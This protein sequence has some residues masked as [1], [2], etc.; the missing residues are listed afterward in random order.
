MHSSL[1]GKAAEIRALLLNLIDTL[2]EGAALPP[3]R[4]A[5]GGVRRRAW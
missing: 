1:P 5:V 4:E 3:E 2:A